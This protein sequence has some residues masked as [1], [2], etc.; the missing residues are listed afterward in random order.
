ML[1]LSVSESF[2]GQ[3]PQW[4]PDILDNIPFATQFLSHGHQPDCI[5]TNNRQISSKKNRT[6]LQ[7]PNGNAQI[8]CWETATAR[9]KH[10]TEAQKIQFRKPVILSQVRII[11]ERNTYFQNSEETCRHKFPT[12][13]TKSILIF[14]DKADAFLQPTKEGYPSIF[15]GPRPSKPCHG[16]TRY[17]AGWGQ[18]KGSWPKPATSDF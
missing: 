7:F 6:M 4:G 9:N 11:Q 13:Q 3:K 8:P 1:H 17:V 18:L 12:T 16:P 2:S 5:H 14:S 15:S 10:L